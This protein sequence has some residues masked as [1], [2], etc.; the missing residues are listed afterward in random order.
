[1]AQYRSVYKHS[2]VVSFQLLLSVSLLHS[3]TSVSTLLAFTAFDAQSRTNKYRRTI[4][5]RIY[6]IYR[7]NIVERHRKMMPFSFV[8]WIYSLFFGHRSLQTH[9]KMCTYSMH[10]R[11]CWCQRHRK[12]IFFTT[13]WKR[14]QNYTNSGNIF[15]CTTLLLR[16][17]TLSRSRRS[18]RLATAT[19]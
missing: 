18:L 4:C 5:N 3:C 9:R 10:I 17:F 1:M 6:R 2:A 8:S 16:Y 14:T 12:W 11:I 7:S 13:L 15:Q 19:F